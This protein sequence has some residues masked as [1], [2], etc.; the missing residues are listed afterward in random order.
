M[1]LAI[2]RFANLCGKCSCSSFDYP[3]RIERKKRCP[4]LC[5]K[6]VPNPPQLSRNFCW[7]GRYL[8]PDLHITV[9]FQWFAADGNV[10]MIA[11]STADPVHFTNIIYQDF[12]YSFTTKWPGLQPPFLPPLEK[13]QPVP[14]TFEQLNAFL[15]QHSRFVG[16]EVLQE[17][18]VERHVNHFRIAVALPDLPSGA[19]FRLPITCVDM[20]VDR[21]DSSKFWKVLQFGLQ[22]LYDPE[23]N[24]YIVVDRMGDPTCVPKIKLPPACMTSKGVAS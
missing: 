6:A 19:Y 3:S 7:Q 8:V 2:T 10:Q 9:P 20:Y 11:G 15:A 1:R 5:C 4:K 13:C 22:N 17:C 23:L 12:F 18:G 24:E 16:P 14:F 21:E